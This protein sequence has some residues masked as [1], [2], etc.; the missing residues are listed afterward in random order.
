M[1][2]GAYGNYS[3]ILTEACKYIQGLIPDPMRPVK[4][5]LG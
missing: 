5:V 2:P 1:W 3:Q 4:K